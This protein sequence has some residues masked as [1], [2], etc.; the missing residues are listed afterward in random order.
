MHTNKEIGRFHDSVLT[1]TAQALKSL[2]V[3]GPAEPH[4]I[5]GKRL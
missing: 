4:K 2:P 3:Q 5:T 1:G